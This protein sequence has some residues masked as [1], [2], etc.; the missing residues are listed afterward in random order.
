MR[1]DQTRHVPKGACRGCL[2]RS[3][4]SSL[5]RTRLR[6]PDPRHAIKALHPAVTELDQGVIVRAPD[7]WPCEPI[8][9]RKRAA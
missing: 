6:L 1:R 2:D 8:M 5:L 3:A 4:H 9:P 7:R